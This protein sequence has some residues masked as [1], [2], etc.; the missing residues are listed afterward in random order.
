M[1]EDYDITEENYNKIVEFCKDIKNRNLIYKEA[2]KIY[3][4]F[5]FYGMCSPMQ[6]AITTILSIPGYFELT[7][8]LLPEFEALKPNKNSTHDEFWWHTRQYR[9]E[10]SEDDIRLAK[11]DILI[12][13]TKIP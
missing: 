5:K 11:F 3:K 12:S 8:G 10:I 9:S 4:S 1:D 6:E 2:K 7:E 13:E